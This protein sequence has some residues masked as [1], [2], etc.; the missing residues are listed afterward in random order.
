MATE[1]LEN[2]Q[3]FFDQKSNC[4][5]LKILTHKINSAIPLPWLE[6][7]PSKLQSAYNLYGVLFPI[8]S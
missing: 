8:S 6:R 2:F 1:F 4:L 3:I 7:A 5:K